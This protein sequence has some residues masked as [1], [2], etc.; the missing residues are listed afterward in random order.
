MEGPVLYFTV[1]LISAL[2]G[3]IP[4]GPINLTVVKTTVDNHAGRGTEMA[5]AASLVE[6]VQAIVAIFFGVIISRFL[7]T[8]PL[9]SLSIALLF[10]GLALVILVRKPRPSLP[11]TK[12]EKSFFVRGLVIATFN[13]QA[14]P[15]WIFALAAISQYFEFEY[16]GIHLFSF[17]A[18]VFTGKLITLYGF[19]LASVWLKSHLQQSCAL[20]NRLLASVLFF[21]GASQLWNAVTG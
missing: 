4:F 7:E 11:Q 9:I 5:V 2:I 19:V 17:L 16:V 12:N 14:V 15:F 18:G 21:I 10:I 1:A 13:P 3:T 6:I 20:V 8:S